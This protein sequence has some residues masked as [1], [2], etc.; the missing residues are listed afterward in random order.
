MIFMVNRISVLVL[1]LF[2]GVIGISAQTAPAGPAD[3]Q[4]RSLSSGQK[5]KVEGAVVSKDDNGTFIIRDTTGNDTRVVVGP[6]AGDQVLA[7]GKVVMEHLESVGRDHFG[8]RGPVRGRG[9]P[10]FRRRL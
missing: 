9:C 6:E 2:I 3:G 7:S 1:A 5:Y 10:Q 4:V 8:G